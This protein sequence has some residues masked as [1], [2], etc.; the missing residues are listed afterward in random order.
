MNP[1]NM[2]RLDR[3]ITQS[4][5]AYLDFW[6][7]ERIK[8]HSNCFS[9]AMNCPHPLY[10]SNFRYGGVNFPV[11]VYDGLHKLFSNQNIK[12]S[13]TSAGGKYLGNDATLPRKM[14]GAYIVAA[15][16]HMTDTGPNAHFIRQGFD[17]RWSHQNGF[18]GSV[19]LLD[20]NI[21]KSKDFID[22]Y[23]EADPTIQAEFIG[24]FS[25]PNH[26]LDITTNRAIYE[27][28]KKSPGLLPVTGLP[29]SYIFNQVVIY[30]CR[31]ALAQSQQ[32]ADKE[33]LEKYFDCLAM[34][35]YIDV[36]SRAS[37]N[38]LVKQAY[39]KMLGSK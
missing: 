11:D 27:I 1:K 25:V 16:R 15:F 6:N 24:W 31:R 21:K 17:G 10:I 3:I 32:L 29:K 22:I 38:T 9:Y 14:L 4:D 19:D 20:W 23:D 39:Q 30:D 13:V 7:D 26:G 34:H 37:S 2:T 35:K 5:E 12:R 28:N 36:S 33:Y 8:S 18:S